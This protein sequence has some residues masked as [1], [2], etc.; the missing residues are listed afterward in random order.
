MSNLK[1]HVVNQVLAC[2]KE[3]TKTIEK[4]E[5]DVEKLENSVNSLM[6]EHEVEGGFCEEC[7]KLVRVNGAGR[8][9]VDCEYCDTLCC[10]D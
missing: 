1:E 2:L 4:L 8:G 5:K 3:Q 6:N 9:T 7:G 10:R